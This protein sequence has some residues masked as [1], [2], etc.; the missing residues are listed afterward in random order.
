MLLLSSCTNTDKE[1]IL[2]LKIIKHKILSRSFFPIHLYEIED[3]HNHHM[4][5]LF[6]FIDNKTL[7]RGTTTIRGVKYQWSQD[8]S[9]G[10]PLN[11]HTHLPALITEEFKSVLGK[12]NELL[13]DIPD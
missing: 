12:F 6:L 2:L 4:H 3:L 7:M 8:K 13:T 10:I 1:E 9:Y 5:S 11:N